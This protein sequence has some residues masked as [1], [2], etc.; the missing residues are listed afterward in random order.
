MRHL[1]G[2]HPPPLTCYDMKQ[3]LHSGSKQWHVIRSLFNADRLV[4]RQ[5]KHYLQESAAA[6]REYLPGVRGPCDERSCR[7]LL[8][9]TAISFRDPRELDADPDVLCIG[10]THI[11][12]GFAALFFSEYV[13][14]DMHMERTRNRLVT[15][16]V[17]CGQPH[18]APVA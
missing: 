10:A 12:R 14:N 17:R 8:G 15:H 3:S 9:R 16:Y 7:L 11:T 2:R 6:N 18:V 1:R 5:K 4:R 13:L